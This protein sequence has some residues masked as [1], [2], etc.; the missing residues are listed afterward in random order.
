MGKNGGTE[1]RDGETCRRI[2]SILFAFDI[3]NYTS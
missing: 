1:D 3:F 2:L